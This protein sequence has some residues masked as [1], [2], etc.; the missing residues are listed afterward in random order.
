MPAGP[1]PRRHDIDLLR[2]G[3]TFLLFPFHAAR[4]L[5]HQPWHVKSPDA[6]IGFDFFVW[7][8]HQFHMP[9]FFTLAG[10]SLE[11]ALHVRTEAAVRRERYA[12]RDRRRL[13]RRRDPRLRAASRDRR[14]RLVRLSPRVG[15][16]GVRAASDGD[17]HHGVL[18]R[19]PLAA[20]GSS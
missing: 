11:R 6:A 17:R 12:E 19:A 8:I 9:L 4:P 10:W 13:R 7:F 5:D 16:P 3:A 15:P 20:A 1:Q 18:A 2:I 14:R